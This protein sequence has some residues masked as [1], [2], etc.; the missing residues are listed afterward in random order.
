MPVPSL[1]ARALVALM[2]LVGFYLCTFVL[3][4]FLFVAPCVYVYLAGFQG[5]VTI[6]VFIAAWAPACVIL[7]GALGARPAPFS[8]NGIELFPTENA[9]L[10]ALLEEVAAK[11]G[12]APPTEVH[13]I[14]APTVGVVET[15]GLFSR[16][17]RRVLILGA[18]L[19]SG[20]TIEQ[21]RAIFAH[22]MG[23]FVGGDTR[24][25]GLVSYT[26]QVFESVYKASAKTELSS[27]SGI[28]GNVA[29]EMTH[30]I[31]T[32]FV[33]LYMRFFLMVTRPTSRKQEIA[34]DALSVRIG[35]RAAAMS[36]LERVHVLSTLYSAYLD[37]EVGPAFDAGAAPL[38][39]LEGFDVFRARIAERGL[40]EKLTALVH[41]EKTDPFDSHP[42][43]ADRVAMMKTFPEEER[44]EVPNG[45]RRAR[46]LVEIDEEKLRG[47][48][49]DVLIDKVGHGQGL[50]R[51][52][53]AAI[54]EEKLPVKIKKESKALVDVLSQHFPKAKGTGAIFRATVK[55]LGN[56]SF[57]QLAH[58]IAPTISHV[59]P[60]RREAMIQSLGAR[61]LTVLFEAC[62]LKRGATIEV[63]LGE[64][65]L[66]FVIDGERVLPG[67]LAA[68]AMTDSAAAA[69]V[70]RWAERLRSSPKAAPLEDAKSA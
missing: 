16:K 13:L 8:P 26:H 12:T 62:L 42:A 54:V 55:S 67:D 4:A 56:G 5:L 7:M 43:Y 46:E 10:Y 40:E 57:V 39:L 36:A 44:T 31:G 41:A 29:T 50:P 14:V 3:S 38:E 18:P 24:L 32:G 2:L 64:P 53:W 9:A 20:L 65:S 25:S 23:H 51:L 68:R 58:L 35:G 19:L 45:V 15:G 66:V 11:A 30:A 60:S 70:A 59:M 33:R 37:A 21:L 22:E 27:S 52:K 49:L 34:A 69:E 1:R 61:I 48:I 47:W 28:Y 63:S 17:R 6:V